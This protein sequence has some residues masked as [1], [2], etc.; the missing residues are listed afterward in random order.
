MEASIC[1]LR[2]YHLLA[3]ICLGN[4]FAYMTRFSTTVTML[5]MDDLNLTTSQMA[6][7]ESSF[8][9]GYCLGVAP[10]GFIADKIGA[11]VLITIAIGGS[12][13][14]SLLTEVLD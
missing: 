3:L 14:I 13:A 11:R 6:Q 10:M 1:K 5:A 8:F 4:T 9:Y 2:R 12:G 7:I